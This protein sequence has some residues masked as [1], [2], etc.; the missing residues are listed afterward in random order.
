LLNRLFSLFR[1]K[2]TN[3]FTGFDK[4]QKERILKKIEEFVNLSP[5]DETYYIKAFTHR[6]YLDKAQEGM[7]S[8]ERLEFLGDSIL[9]KIVADYLFKEYPNKKEGFLT[10][11]RSH[12]VNKH[13]LEKIGFEL[14]LN[15]LLFINDKYL[16]NSKKNISNIVA[17]CLE[18]LIAAIYL[19]L[20]ETAAQIFVEKYIIKPQVIS[21]RVNYDKNYKGQLLEFA[22]ANK[23]NQPIY[24]VLEQTGPQHDK[25]YKIEVFID[26]NISGVGIGPNKKIA[27]QKAAKLALKNAN[28]F[29][30][31]LE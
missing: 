8:N 4:N 6:S 19:D 31:N 7:K 5:K 26:E 30:Q 27:E 24:N 23:L 12:L 11:A 28:S 10:K 14:N 21:G 29:L 15:D 18:A 20:G 1:R 9:G 13:S 22:H 16:V 3:S 2:K 17:D 25:I